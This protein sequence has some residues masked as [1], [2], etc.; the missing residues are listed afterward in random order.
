MA[1]DSSTPIWLFHRIIR[2]RAFEKRNEGTN[3]PEATRSARRDELC[4]EKR[5]RWPV[6]GV[7]TLA[8]FLCVLATFSGR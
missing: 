6:V 3:Y 7:I 2:K 1:A 4:Q 5:R 8:D